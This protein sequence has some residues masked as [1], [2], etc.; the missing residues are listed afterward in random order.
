M[1]DSK[2]AGSLPNDPHASSNWALQYVGATDAWAYGTGRGVTVAVLDTG[3]DTDHADLRDNMWRNPGEIA[4][5]GI[6]NDRNGFVDDVHGWNFTD[7]GARQDVEDQN[8]HGTHVAGLIA[9]EANNGIGIAGVAPD[10]QIMAVKVLNDQGT[11]WTNQM[12][13][14]IDYAIANGA[15]VINMSLAGSSALADVELAIGRAQEAGVVV[16]IAAGN[17]GGSEALYP[18]RYTQKYDNVITVAASTPSDVLASWSNYSA[19]RSTVDLAAPGSG[20]YST[21]PG[22]GYGWKSGTS[23]ATPIVAGAVAAVWDAFPDWSYKQVVDAITGAVDEM[24]SLTKQTVTNGILNLRAAIENN[25][26]DAPARNDAPSLAVGMRV[27][28]IAENTALPSGGIRIADIAVTDDGVGV[29]VVT[30]AGADPAL[31][32]LRD[33]GLYLRAGVTLDF[34]TKPELSV[35]IRVDDAAIGTSFEAERVVTVAVTD[36]DETPARDESPTVEEPVADEPPTGDALPKFDFLFEAGTLEE[37]VGPT[38]LRDL[39]GNGHDARAASATSAALVVAGGFAFDGTD[40]YE[41]ANSEALNTDAS[42][43][44]KTLSFVLELGR[45]VAG[46]QFIYEQ[47]GS[48]RGLSVTVEDGALHLTGWNL[49][50]QPWGPKTVSTEVS[51]GD[52]LS[53]SMV[54]D[55]AAGTL[56]GYADGVL[57]GTATG[58]G[59]LFRHGDSI[60]LGDVMGKSR[61]ADGS[62]ATAGNGF[63]GKIFSAS[64]RDGAL[65]ASQVASLHTDFATRFETDRSAAPAYPDEFVFRFDGSMLGTS[66]APLALTDLSGSGHDAR[67]AT[68]SQAAQAADGG[69]RFD[70]T[71]VY[72]IADSVALNIGGPYDA[73]TLSFV[74]ELG[75]DVATRQVLYEQGGIWRGLA[76]SIEDGALHLSGW[77]LAET[78]WNVSTVS[79]EVAAGDRLAVSLVLDAAAGQLQGF[80][81]GVL[82]GTATGVGPL[83]AHTDDIGLGGVW[84]RTR[85][86]DGDLLRDVEGFRGTLY[87]AAA[88]NDALTV[89]EVAA[90]HAE[91]AS[92][93]SLGAAE[94]GGTEHAPAE[95]TVFAASGTLPFDVRGGN[96]RQRLAE[97][98]DRDEDAFDDFWASLPAAFVPEDAFL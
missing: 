59:T 12:A 28:Q 53:V 9:A 64:S 6:D 39:S 62:V 32:E 63:E 36:V 42:Y 60:G 15:K 56:K 88:Q 61:D 65:D 71:D 35:A 22:G 34:E 38:D 8:S 18:G 92:K 82:V 74:V 57:F 86:A 44:A 37:G 29:N 81:D 46:R 48:A 27:D 30:L 49:P 94:V 85:D 10:A 97:A 90:L 96:L 2:T 68:A 91:F 58:V 40:A 70:G 77:N 76:V 25:L 21:T 11:G 5:D 23:M 66:D 45:D 84:G 80:V 55:A 19:S 72:H 52:R 95:A 26:T 7:A 89:Q 79:T 17:A 69:L 78:A 3:I 67:A 54:F 13:N 20:L 73:K 93:W 24:A 14:G 87:E 1:M 47:G 98:R 83:H 41:V 75:Q 51:A 4:G 31:F 50:E 43:D 33:G 16:V